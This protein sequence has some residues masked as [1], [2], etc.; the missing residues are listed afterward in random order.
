MFSVLATSSFR[1]SPSLSLLSNRVGKEQVRNAVKK[2]G[3]N[4]QVVASNT[5]QMQKGFRMKKKVEPTA[6]ENHD[7]VHYMRPMPENRLKV[8]ILKQHQTV[9]DLPIFRPEEMTDMALGKV[10]AFTPTTNTIMKSFGVPRN[11]V[12]DFRLLSKPSS[13][14]RDVTLR[15]IDKLDEVVASTSK[16]TKMVFTGPPGNGKSYLMLQAIEYAQSVGYIVLYV[17]RAS[18][19][20]DSST[21]YTYD[22]RTR[23]YVQPKYSHLL[24]QRLSSVNDSSLRTLKLSKDVLAE[25]GSVRLSVGSS[26]YDLADLGLRDPTLAPTVLSNLFAELAQQ[27]TIPVLLAID[28]IQ[29]LYNH[30]TLY[31][32]PMYENIKPYHLSVPRLLLEYAS[33][34]KSFSRGMVIGAISGSNTNWPVPPELQESLGLTPPRPVSV[35]EKRYPEIEQYASGLEN[36]PV[37]EQLTLDEAAAVYDLWRKDNALHTQSTDELFLSKYTEACGNPR[38]FV[39]EGLFRTMTT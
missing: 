3:V 16:V 10:H 9:L 34:K 22:P 20:V 37:P 38:R 26:L 12:V 7:G 13:V 32:N 27:S 2:A 5:K 4:R 8:D 17:P 28:D 29:S 33:N 24:L 31:K 35:Y 39:W 25:D 14:I 19:L 36:F 30:T 21:M 18:K 1:P 23:T 15:V 11:V 6:K